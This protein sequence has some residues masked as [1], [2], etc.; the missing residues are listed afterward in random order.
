MVEVEHGIS[1]AIT[2]ED[3]SLALSPPKLLVSSSRPIDDHMAAIRR[4]AASKRSLMKMR[5]SRNAISGSQQDGPPRDESKSPGSPNSSADEDPKRSKAD[6]ST[7]E[8]DPCKYSPSKNARGEDPGNSQ[9]RSVFQ[10]RMR[11]HSAPVYLTPNDNC[12]S[13]S[14][15]PP[16]IVC[17]A[18]CLFCLILRFVSLLA[19]YVPCHLPH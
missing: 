16:E 5:A 8:S 18:S 2:N 1:G 10:R 9:V 6:R 4:T 11:N 19:L 15:P 14:P 17:D 3:S 7:N 12:T 13:K